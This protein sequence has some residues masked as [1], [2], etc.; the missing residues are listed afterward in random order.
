MTWNSLYVVCSTDT[1]V[2]T[3]A[4]P[5]TVSALVR[6]DILA[7]DFRCCSADLS[8]LQTT[9]AVGK[10]GRKSVDGRRSFVHALTL[11]VVAAIVAL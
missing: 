8:S 6:S 1:L 11:V 7:A 3:D 9:T 5:G 4:T 10:A 2:C